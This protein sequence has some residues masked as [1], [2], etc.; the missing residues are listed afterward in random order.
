[1][2][3]APG[4]WLTAETEEAEEKKEEEEEEE[5]HHQAR[6]SQAAAGA[7]SKTMKTVRSSV[8]VGGASVTG[9]KSSRVQ[10]ALKGEDE[11]ASIDEAVWVCSSES[12]KGSAAGE[13]DG[14]IS[15]LVKDQSFSSLPRPP[16][17]SLARR[18]GA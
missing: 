3:S 4:S 18:R 10:V 2:C 11:G 6:V 16:F 13:A 1:M 8:V 7:P 15:I 14:S 17:S 9:R 12:L 5:E